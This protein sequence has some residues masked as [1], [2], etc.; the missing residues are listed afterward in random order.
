MIAVTAMLTMPSSGA[1]AQTCNLPEFDDRGNLTGRCLDPEPGQSGNGNG[2]GQ[3]VSWTPPPGW[4]RVEYRIP[5][6][7]DDGTPCIRIVYEW[8]PGE[9]AA[10]HTTMTNYAWFRWYDRLTADGSTMEACTVEAGAPAIDPAMVRQ[11]IVSQ[12]PLPAPS[13][14]PGRAITG[15]RSYL[16]VGAPTTFNDGI[17]GD[18]LPIQVTIDGTAQYRV[19]WGDGTVE[20]YPSSG[21][22]Y[23]DGDITHVYTDAGDHTVTVTPVWTVRWQGGGLDVSFTAELVPSTVDLPVGEVQ[24]VRTD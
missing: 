21:G 9:Q 15:L 16:D 20:T 22:P 6:Y 1:A 17:T 3:G 2:N 10:N 14:D 19:D 4:E 13:I 23:P 12:L 24:S 8:M 11:M 7:E 18:V 5:D